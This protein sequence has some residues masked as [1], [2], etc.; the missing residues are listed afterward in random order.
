MYILQQRVSVLIQHAFSN[1]TATQARK[2]RNGYPDDTR[3]GVALITN[4]MTAWW[5][6]EAELTL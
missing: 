2:N 1:D 4:K 6:L 5:R 3:K